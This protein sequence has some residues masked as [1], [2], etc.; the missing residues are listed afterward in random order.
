MR[1][2]NTAVAALIAATS[3]VG[4][5]S[6]ASAGGWLADT[7]IRP[8]SPEAADAA[9]RVNR[10]LGQP[11]DHAITRGM[12]Y[13]APGSGTAVE[14]YWQAQRQGMIPQGPG[15]QPAPGFNRPAVGN[16]CTTAAGR[17]G[18]GP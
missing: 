7:F 9:D 2:I 3:T 5:T 12:D 10:D 16:F 11:V 6:S 8:I 1:K 15:F 17:F 4:F 14:M 18:P 13:V